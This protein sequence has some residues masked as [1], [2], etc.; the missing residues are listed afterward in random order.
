MIPTWEGEIF[1]ISLHTDRHMCYML[2]TDAVVRDAARVP[3]LTGKHPL[4][5]IKICTTIYNEVNF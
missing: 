4:L 3:N 1:H 2:I 5:H